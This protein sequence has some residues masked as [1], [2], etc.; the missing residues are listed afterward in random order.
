MD[1]KIRY[2]AAQDVGNCTAIYN[3]YVQNTNLTFDTTPRTEEEAL[4]WIGKYSTQGNFRL[5]IAEADGKMAGWA[6]NSE[7]RSHPAF[8]KTT[9]FS[10]YIDNRFCRQGVGSLLYEKMFPVIKDLGFHVVL[11]GIGLP[12]AASICLHEKHGFTKVGIFSEYAQ[13]NGKWISS[14]WYQAIL[15]RR[16]A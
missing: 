16:H 9:E 11:A 12:N 2:A 8:N 4:K 5:W 14:V 6:C 7:Y 1:F 10:I 3:Y 13:K 15:D